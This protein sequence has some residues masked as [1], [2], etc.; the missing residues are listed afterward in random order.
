MITAPKPAD[1]PITTLS[2]I[3]KVRSLIFLL[4]QLRNL[5]IGR[6]ST[7]NA[8]IKTITIHNA[9]FLIKFANKGV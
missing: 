7:M 6:L 2:R 3:I 9:C 1:T 8:N 5:S 4:R